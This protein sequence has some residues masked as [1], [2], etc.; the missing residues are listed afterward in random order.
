MGLRV[1]SY[2]ILFAP[3][4]S[5]SVH[6]TSPFSPFAGLRAKKDRKRPSMQIGASDKKKTWTITWSSTFFSGIGKHLELHLRVKAH[7]KT[8]EH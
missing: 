8:R 6:F 1:Q 7:V 3:P 4:Y 2:G 5:F